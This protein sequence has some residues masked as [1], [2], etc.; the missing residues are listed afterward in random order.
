MNIPFKK[1][2]LFN[3]RSVSNS[4]GLIRSGGI[5]YSPE[6]CMNQDGCGSPPGMHKG[7]LP[8]GFLLIQVPLFQFNFCLTSVLKDLWNLFVK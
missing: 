4:N 1:R 6:N 3:Y 2:K 8:Y 7:I 5:Y